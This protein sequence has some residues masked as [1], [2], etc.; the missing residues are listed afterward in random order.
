VILA[1]CRGVG[2]TFVDA[3]TEVAAL[4]GVDLEVQPGEFLLIMGPSGSGKSTLLSILAGLLR[5]SRGEVTLVNHRLSGMDAEALAAV[6][7]RHV[8]FVFQSFHLFSAL[9]ALGNIECVLEM[10]GVPRTERRQLAEAALDEVGLGARR[11]HRSSELSGGER[12]R[13]ALARALAASPQIIFGDEPTSALDASTAALVLERLRAFVDARRSVVLVTHDE[14]VR[15]LA[16]RTITLA[17]GRVQGQ[18]SE[19]GQNRAH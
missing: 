19:Q 18:P 16:T 4:D 13:V 10:K 11:H 14:R 3:G 17:Y 7:R 2:Q 12:Q 6:R 8:G 1:S 9:T 5:P 15:A